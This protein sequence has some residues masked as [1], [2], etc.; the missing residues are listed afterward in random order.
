MTFLKEEAGFLEKAM[1]FIKGGSTSPRGKKK[2]EK[3]E[4]E[5]IINTITLPDNA[6]CIQFYYDNQ[7]IAVQTEST[8]LGIDIYT[9]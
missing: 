9:H 6:T 4:E 3:S 8:V 7:R 5:E 1:N 2:G